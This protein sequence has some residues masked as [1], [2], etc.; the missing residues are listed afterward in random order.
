MKP[1]VGMLYPVAGLVDTYTPGE[2]ITYE[3]P[4]VVS[5]ARGATLT[6][7]ASDGEFY[8]DDVLLDSDLSIVGYTLDFEPAGLKSAVRATLLGETVLENS[9]GYR[10]TGKN[11]PDVGF[12]YVKKMREDDDEDGSVSNVYEGWFFYK[13][14]FRINSEEARTKERNTEWRVPTVNGKGAGVYLDDGDDPTFSDHQ[15]FASLSD[16]KAW[17]LAQFGAESTATPASGSETPAAG[18]ETTSNP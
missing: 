12:G 3:T 14:K 10:I 15:D 1:N 16:A 17:V 7:E 5:Q 9:A 4:F 8:G 13:V 11:P 2:G 18:S 6:W